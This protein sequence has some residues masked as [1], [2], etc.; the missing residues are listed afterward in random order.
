MLISF[1]QFVIILCSTWLIGFAYYTDMV[2]SNFYVNTD[3]EFMARLDKT[4]NASLKAQA[5]MIHWLSFNLSYDVLFFTK[6]STRLKLC[7]GVMTKSRNNGPIPYDYVSQTIVSILARTKLANQ[8]NIRIVL[9][10][11]DQ[12]SADLDQKLSRLVHIEQI[13]KPSSIRVDLKNYVNDK[14]VLGL[15]FCVFL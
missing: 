13:Q 6:D 7:I 2:K 5:E 1:F 4:F 12:D 14:K 3:D 9:F 10:N 15:S 11:A 8:A